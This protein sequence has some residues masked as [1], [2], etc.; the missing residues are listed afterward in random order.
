VGNFIFEVDFCEITSR[1]G[2]SL[3]TKFVRDIYFLYRRAAHLD[4]DF[5]DIPEEFLFVIN[6]D[7]NF[8]T[9]THNCAQKLRTYFQKQTVGYKKLLELIRKQKE[10]ASK[11]KQLDE[12]KKQYLFGTASRGRDGVTYVS[13]KAKQGGNGPLWPAK[14]PA[15]D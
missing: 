14:K 4:E 1:V 15:Q 9:R 3:A 12:L 8:K 6:S 5:A 7:A 2:N 11:E 13:Q 10:L